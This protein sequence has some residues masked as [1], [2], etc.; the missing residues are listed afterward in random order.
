MYQYNQIPSTNKFYKQ[1]YLNNHTTYKNIT[2]PNF[3][4]YNQPNE[5]RIGFLAPFLLGG[6]AGGLAAPYFTNGYGNYYN[7]YY[8]PTYPYYPNYYYRPF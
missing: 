2:P 7:N 4:Y 5:E 3:T 1:N 6:I 8:Y